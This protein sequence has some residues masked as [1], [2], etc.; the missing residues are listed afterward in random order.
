[1][2]VKSAN[3]LIKGWYNYEKV[4][5]Y[6]PG[7]RWLFKPL[8]FSI[9]GVEKA[10]FG[11]NYTYWRIASLIMHVSACFSLYRLLWAIK[12]GWLS[13]SVALYFALM[14]TCVNAVLYEQIASYTLFTALILT[15]LYYI[16]V[17]KHLWV[18]VLCLFIAPYINETGI[19]IVALCCVYLWMIH[20]KKWAVACGLLLP[21]Y[22]TVY[23]IEK[24]VNPA[25]GIFTEFGNLFTWATLDIGIY[26]VFLIIWN[27]GMQIIFPAI[28]SLVPQYKLSSY[29]VSL[30]PIA[31]GISLMFNIVSL[32][33]M[34]WLFRR[35]LRNKKDIPFVLLVG[36]I[37]FSF[38]LVVAV[39]RAKTHG[40]GYVV[41]NSFN[42]Y[43]FLAWVIVLAYSLITM[44]RLRKNHFNYISVCFV[45]LAMISG[46]K[47]YSA[48]NDIK[49]SE[50][51]LR[52]YLARLD[53][54]ISEHPDQT[55]N[56]TI[57]SSLE[58]DLEITLW[59]YTT[60]PATESTTYTVPQILYYERWADNSDYVLAY[61]PETDMLRVVEQ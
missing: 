5:I 28:W 45:V 14:F 17:Q 15:A 50:T 22:F 59:R 9:V 60:P 33:I 56:S 34:G 19:I 35:G 1:M 51:P 48:N 55:F 57:S 13:A 12:K 8:L 43:M 16:Y 44:L 29:S 61:Y 31:Y 24:L 53:N 6:A 52:N 4:R 40:T 58:K 54:F 49:Q 30:E 7:D 23:F 27:W 41:G 18:S 11:I 32:F 36:S 47:V 26:A 2:G 25:Y 46:V 42:A 20:C 38:T 39:F 37:L 3:S 21:I 10:L